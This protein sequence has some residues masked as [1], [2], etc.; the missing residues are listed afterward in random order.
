MAS[1]VLLERDAGT[2]RVRL[3]RYAPH[4][5]MALHAHDEHGVSVV[6]DGA[7]V[8]EAEHRAVTATARWTVVKPAA[9]AHA[10]RFGP[11]P[12]TLLALVSPDGFEDVG[13]HAWRWLDGPATFRAGLRLLRAVKHGTRGDQDETLTEFVASLGEPAYS[14]GELPW[15]SAVRRALDDRSRRESVATLAARAGVHPV[16]LARR[17]RGAFGVSLREFRQIAQV[18]RATQLILRTRRPLSEI[19]HHCGFA[20]HSHMCRAFRAV[21]GVNP[22]A[23]RAS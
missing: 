21:A 17:F 23:L 22:A 11:A 6:L 18:R 10:N 19:A 8:E 13:H 1:T 7:L 4:H 16:Y 12:T 3:V 2:V 5:Q 20:D 9:T 15:L 14:P